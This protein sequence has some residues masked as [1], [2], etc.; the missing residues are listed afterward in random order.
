M[1]WNRYKQAWPHA[2]HS[3]F[4]VSK[5]HKW[6]V[7]NY[8]SGKVVV[9]I[10]GAGGSSHSWHQLGSILAE[11]Y[12]IIAIDLPGQGFTKLGAINRCG[13][14]E[15]A[16][17][18]NRV[19][20]QMDIS[21]YAII[22]HSAGGVVALRLAELLGEPIPIV[23]INPAL[24]NFKG[25]AG[26]FFPLIA[27]TLAAL[28]M[29][30]S[31][32]TASS[33]NEKSVKRLIEG[34]GSTLSPN[35]LSYYQSLISS[36]S[37]VNAT[38]SM[39]AQWKLDPILGRLNDHVSRCLFL[40]GENDKAVPPET[41]REAAGKMRHAQVISLPDLGHLAHEEDPRLVASKIIEFLGSP[42]SK[43]V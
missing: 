13:L 22:G 10:H 9:L 11:N 18:L 17:D 32:F 35:E 14:D 36:R 4:I 34:T 39:M 37:H 42:A 15:M 2:E 33:G 26:F 38:L 6:H 28:P 23:G 12:Q 19:L 24:S 43:V 8:G 3:H 40:V 25:P 20:T 7:Q 31:L 27:K 1:D 29:V 21:P 5:P 30:A 41:S 16:E